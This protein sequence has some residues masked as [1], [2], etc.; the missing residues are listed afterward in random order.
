MLAA[1]RKPAALEFG[2]GNNERAVLTIDPVE[3]V[4]DALFSEVTNNARRYQYSQCYCDEERDN[5]FFHGE[6]PERCERAGDA[7]MQPAAGNETG[8]WNS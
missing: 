1:G 4:V 2:G 3:A 6:N 8:L 5:A 7:S